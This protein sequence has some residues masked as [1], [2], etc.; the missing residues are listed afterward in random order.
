MSTSVIGM[1]VYWARTLAL[2]DFFTTLSHNIHSLFIWPSVSIYSLIRWVHSSLVHSYWNGIISFILALLITHFALS[3]SFALCTYISYT[4]LKG[5]LACAAPMYATVRH[6]H[7]HP[8]HNSYRWQ[9]WRLAHPRRCL[10]PP[11]SPSSRSLWVSSHP[12]I[13]FVFFFLTRTRTRTHILSFSVASICRSYCE[14]AFDFSGM[15]FVKLF[16]LPNFPTYI[17]TH[18]HIPYFSLQSHRTIYQCASS[19]SLRFLQLSE[20]S[21]EQH[22]CNWYENPSPRN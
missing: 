15:C 12:S 19:P 14:F 5:S 2:L 9:W 10:G 7:G 1:F 20:P 16:I 17:H 3:S 11:L 18:T 21:K 8:G 4:Y 13:S 22:F 6:N